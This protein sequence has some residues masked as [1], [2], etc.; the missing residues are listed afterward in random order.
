MPIIL[1]HTDPLRAL[2]FIL[3]RIASRRR[4]VGSP[5]MHRGA[6]IR[7]DQLKRAP[8]SVA[9]RGTAAGCAAAG[10]C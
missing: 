6:A 5:T 7:R 2:Y 1:R 9:I 10:P 4:A 8:R 3:I